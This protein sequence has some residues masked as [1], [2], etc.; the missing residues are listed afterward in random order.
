MKRII[1][2]TSLICALFLFNDELVYSHCDTMEGPVIADAKKAIEHNNVNYVL[3]WVKPDAEK[4]IKNAF[5]LAM[6]VSSYGPEAKELS[7]RYFYETL[8]RIHR[9]GEG[10]PYTG[11]KPAGIPI[12]EKIKAADKAIEEGN[13]NP[14]KNMVSDERFSELEKHFEKVMKLKNFN[15]NNVEAGREYVEAY[16]RFFHFAEGEDGEQHFH[17]HG[18]DVSHVSHLPWIVSLLFLATSIIF[19]V[20]YFREKSKS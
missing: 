13:L 10:V 11:I 7:E 8:V 19:V 2:L 9:V 17:G 14:L 6:K 20:L 18:E 15:V 4:E 16:T 12:D 1:I 3:K 5:N